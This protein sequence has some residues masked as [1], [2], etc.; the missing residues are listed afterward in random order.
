MSRGH[1]AQTASDALAKKGIV[2]SYKTLARH[3]KKRRKAAA[4]EKKAKAIQTMATAPMSTAPIVPDN[5][6]PQTFAEEPK[7]ESA[8]S[9]APPPVDPPPARDSSPDYLRL[10]EEAPDF[11]AIDALCETLREKLD[12]MDPG[13]PGMATVAN[14]LNNAITKRHKFRPAP[15]PDP[16][17]VQRQARRADKKTLKKFE[18]H[19]VKFEAEAKRLGI[20]LHCR[21]KLTEAQL[22]ELY[23]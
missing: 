5:T 2:I 23:G 6:Q 3:Q 8:P 18:E 12:G 1:T 15:P 19:L 13:A 17:V 9:V 11:V 21:S 22:Q 16:H 10:V 20:C 14:A 4:D 7:P